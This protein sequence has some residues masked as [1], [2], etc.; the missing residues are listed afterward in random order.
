[1]A[2]IYL[3]IPYCKQACHYCDF[4]F[5]TVLKNKDLMIAA[6]KKEIEIRKNYLEGAK[7]ETIYFGGGTPSILSVSELRYFIDAIFSNFEVENDVEVTLEA[8]PDDLKAQKVK[9]FKDTIINRFSI[10]IQSFFEEDLKWMNRAHNAQEADS[11]VK[12]VQDA[13][14]ENLNLD[15]IYGYPLLSHEKWLQNIQKIIDLQV[16][17]I[18]AYSMT[19]EDQTAL[20][21]FIQKG[22]QKPM[23][24]Q[25]SAEQF[26]LLMRSLK[27]VGYD[28]YEV[29]NFALPVRYSK[30]NTSYWNG[31]PY[32]G[33]GPSAH[34]FNGL[35]R[36]W[37]LRNNAL[38]I[39]NISEN[40]RF[41]EKEI[42]KKSDQFNEYLLTHLRT[43][44]GI[45]MKWMARH[46]PNEMNDSILEPIQEFKRKGWIME[47]APHQIRL[48]E[49]GFL[50]ADFISSEL[51][52]LE[53]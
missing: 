53:S 11:C 52:Y 31:I 33:I 46:F 5:S 35:E 16:P 43:K 47:E 27:K 22:M 4:H 7:I 2:G 3:H 28:H 9:E 21:H 30:H 48:T 13:G 38:Y 20:A 23:Y 45:Q 32:I 26:Q 39:K 18:S 1:M 6:M 25:Q 44:W 37:N 29:S 17:H 10:G 42:L 36:Q 41:F 19:V 14:F 50:Y 8:N 40:R 12:I 51:F 15:L 24:E 49:E 34:S